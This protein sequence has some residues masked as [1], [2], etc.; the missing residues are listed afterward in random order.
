MKVAVANTNKTPRTGSFPAGLLDP[1]LWV[2]EDSGRLLVEATAPST[3]GALTED[4]SKLSV[5]TT[6]TNAKALAATATY[7]QKAILRNASDAD[8]AFGP[9]SDADFDTLGSG[10]SYLLEAPPG[11]RF[12]LAS[13]YIKGAAGKT[14]KVLYL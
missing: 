3:S 5:T 7:A 6:D 9:D 1:F 10:G 11:L 14:L 4:W 8:L 12:N 2:T 13:W